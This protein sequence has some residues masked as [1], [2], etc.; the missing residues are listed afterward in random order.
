MAKRMAVLNKT[1]S[2][3]LHKTEQSTNTPPS[4]RS[5][6]LRDAAW[7]TVPLR[8][9]AESTSRNEGWWQTLKE[10]LRKYYC[11]SGGWCV[12][13]WLVTLLVLLVLLGLGLHVLSPSLSFLVLLLPE[14][15]PPPPP[16]PSPPPPWPPLDI[17]FPDPLPYGFGTTRGWYGTKSSTYIEDLPLRSQFLQFQ[18]NR[19]TEGQTW[20]FISV[21]TANELPNPGDWWSW[22]DCFAELEQVVEYLGTVLGKFETH[23]V[24]G[25]EKVSGL[26][27]EISQRQRYLLNNA[28]LRNALADKKANGLPFTF[29]QAEFDALSTG[30]VYAF[31]YIDVNGVFFKPR[32]YV[33]E[34][35][36]A[37]V[38]AIA[39]RDYDPS[40]TLLFSG[41]FN[42]KVEEC[43]GVCGAY[44]TRAQKT[45]SYMVFN[46]GFWHQVISID[47]A[48][49]DAQKKLQGQQGVYS[50]LAH[51]YCHV[52]QTNKYSP[53]H[54]F[55]GTV[56]YGYR[57]HGEEWGF[58]DYPPN[59][60][61]RWW[62]EG[63]CAIIPELMGEVINRQGQ[64]F[65][66]VSAAIAQIHSDSSIT[67][68]EFA[69]RLAYVEPPRGYGYLTRF[70]W[71]Y[72]ACVY[73][74]KQTSWK[75]A[76]WDWY[77]DFQR[78]RADSRAYSRNGESHMVPGL[79]NVFLHIFNKT[80]VDF[81]KEVYNFVKSDSSI[82]A[83][84]FLPGGNLPV[85]P[86]LPQFSSHA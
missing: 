78:V 84:Y 37:E 66:E 56:D 63:F 44:N 45:R 51:E 81:L 17:S 28:P 2:A 83:D 9:P 5:A 70:H 68:T 29:T 21:P 24:S 86:G 85:I 60:I 40:T 73:F 30:P 32:S 38:N 64:T 3:R 42:Y 35:I 33:N 55:Y 41:R 50:G 59:E 31:T 72:L 1:N 14:P 82:T 10:A 12:G 49:N 39:T 27:W 26:E 22:T 36:N 6:C 75:Y 16:P 46:M 8:A 69:H 43:G 77:H 48:Q 67:E 80:E 57:W 23:M 20:A 25:T 4:V 13:T 11:R 53:E 65:A 7:K 62:V 76:F 47:D 19:A 18:R 74:A 15:P 58:E 61:S 79:D 71:A 52:M 34:R 54:G